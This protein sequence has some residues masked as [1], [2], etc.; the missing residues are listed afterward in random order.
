MARKRRNRY[1][2]RIE[3]G[4][5]TKIPNEVIEAIYQQELSEN[6]S[7]ILWFIVRKTFGWEKD[8]EIITLDVFAENL[9]LIKP[10][11]CEAIL[12][13]QQRN[14]ITDKRNKI[15]QIQMDVERWLPKKKNKK[16]LKVIKIT[17][18][19]NSITDKRNK[20]STKHSPKAN[21]QV[22]KETILKER[23]D[24][25]Q[26]IG[27]IKPDDDSLFSLLKPKTLTTLKKQPFGLGEPKI[28]RSLAMTKKKQVNSHFSDCI[29]YILSRPDIDK[30]GRYFMTMIKE[31]DEAPPP[32]YLSRRVE[33]F[34]NFTGNEVRAEKSTKFENMIEKQILEKAKERIKQIPVI[35]NFKNQIERAKNPQTKLRY[36]EREEEERQKA[37]AKLIYKICS[38][39][40]PSRVKMFRKKLLQVD[41]GNP[42]FKQAIVKGYELHTER[43]Y[44]DTLNEKVA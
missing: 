4:N 23:K 10:R 1:K 39:I 20:I 25:H 28:I 7:K 3:K 22:P 33:L 42:K 31:G 44:S 41:P 27:N 36:Q 34:N 32:L 6:Q 21:P 43:P 35:Y 12:K 18:K 11:I 24:H 15:Y 5:Y 38:L 13:L 9:N 17:D 40:K 16:A 2:E 37:K 29:D 19:R 14:I 8:Q 26:N 30:P